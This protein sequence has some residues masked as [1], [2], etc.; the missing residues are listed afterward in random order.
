MPCHSD[1][2]RTEEEESALARPQKKTAVLPRR[3]VE[4][5]Q[6]RVEKVLAQSPLPACPSTL[7]IMTGH[8]SRHRKTG[9]CQ[10]PQ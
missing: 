3:E 7:L 1:D 5:G 10:S 4:N 6:N 9:N 2:S 8:P